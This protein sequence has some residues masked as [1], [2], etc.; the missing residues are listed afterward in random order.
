MPMVKPPD[1]CF[2]NTL[3][4]G[5]TDFD[6]AD[7]FP[8]QGGPIA[9]RLKCGQRFTG[10]RAFDFHGGSLELPHFTVAVGTMLNVIGHS[11]PPPD[12]QV[13]TGQQCQVASFRVLPG[14]LKGVVARRADLLVPAHTFLDSR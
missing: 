9:D 3:S 10:A 5:N 11:H 12:G 6:I 2:L 7:H 1:P 13:V 4:R 8:F 14:M